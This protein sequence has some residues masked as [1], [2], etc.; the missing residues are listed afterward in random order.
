MQVNVIDMDVKRLRLVY[1]RKPGVSNQIPW[2]QV[3]ESLQ[4]TAKMISNINYYYYLNL[5]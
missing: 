3:L 5:N 1:C 2:K 4:T